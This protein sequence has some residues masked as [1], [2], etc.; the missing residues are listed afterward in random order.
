MPADAALASA[1][2]AL[3]ALGIRPPPPNPNPDLAALGIRAR[4]DTKADTGT[5]SPVDTVA[6]L[7]RGSTR[8]PLP[9][10]RASALPS[11]YAVAP[12]SSKP[13]V[14]PPKAAPRLRDC[15]PTRLQVLTRG[16]TRASVAAGRHSRSAVVA[17]RWVRRR[18]SVCPR[19]RRAAG[20]EVR[21]GAGALR[22]GMRRA[23]RWRAASW[24]GGPL[25][26]ANPNTNPNRT[27]TLTLTEP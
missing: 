5:L 20:A 3:A 9:Q 26:R 19:M 8:P 6:A 14:S 16:L 23:W 25:S 13:P 18:G 24:R 4:A 27:L 22:R 1:P 7:E 2:A 12:A 15:A 21:A 11:S 17:A 10:P